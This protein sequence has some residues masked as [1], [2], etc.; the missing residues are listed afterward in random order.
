MSPAEA[1]SRC[2]A[3]RLAFFDDLHRRAVECG[4]ADRDGARAE[5]TRAI[6][7]LVGVALD[8]LD[9][10]HRHAEPRRDDLREGGGMALAMVVGAEQRLDAAVLLH[11]DRGRLE[12]AD[13]GAKRRRHPRRC[14][15]GG[16][17]HSR[18]CR[19]RAACA[20]ARRQTAAGPSLCSQ[21]HREGATA[22]WE[23]C[24]SRRSVRS[25]SCT[26]SPRPARGCAAESRHGP[27]RARAPLRRRGA[28]ARS[29]PP[30]GRRRGRHRSAPCW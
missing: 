17:P 5:C 3:I 26:A 18:R 7:H 23:N 4:A 9:A 12:K 1:S 2:A 21:R 8:D 13:A 6:G 25:A 24:R 16:I 10:G 29:R 28:P 30:G 15:A 19:S 14:D 20:F 22:P 27:F 11:A